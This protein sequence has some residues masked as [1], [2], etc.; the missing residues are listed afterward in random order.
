MEGQS[1]TLKIAGKEYPLKVQAGQ[2]EKN[3]RLAAE[4]I[5][6]ML[7]KYDERFPNRSTLDKL[8]FV[9]LNEAVGRLST[10]QKYKDLKE[11]MD[12]LGSELESY[13]ST[14]EEPDR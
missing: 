12:K 3:M 9:T 2:S 14:I 8:I 7:S 6:Q 4:N 10:S 11:E 1:I 13:L 5:N